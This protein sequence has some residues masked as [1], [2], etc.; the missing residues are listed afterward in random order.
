MGMTDDE[1]VS[2]L[3]TSEQRARRFGVVVAVYDC[4]P[5]P[6]VL[7]GARFWESLLDGKRVAVTSNTDEARAF[8]LERRQ[9][10]FSN[11]ITGVNHEIRLSN[12]SE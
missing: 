11:E 10:G 7:D 4:D 9:H 6:I 2:V 5:N 3:L 12:G 8:G 1:Q